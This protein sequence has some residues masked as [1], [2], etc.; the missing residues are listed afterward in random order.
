MKILVIGFAFLMMMSLVVALETSVIVQF[1]E[2]NS[3]LV[4][5][6]DVVNDEVF[7]KPI[8]KTF[9]TGVATTTFN[10]TRKEVNILVLVLDKSKKVINTFDDGPFKTGGEI[11]IDLREN[12]SV[13]KIEKVVEEVETVNESSNVTSEET[14]AEIKEE[15]EEALVFPSTSTTRG[16]IFTNDDGSINFLYVIGV[17]LVLFLLV[18]I[19]IVIRGRRRNW[20]ID[21]EE[22]E[23]EDI[24]RQVDEKGREIR[25]IKESSLRRQKLEVAKR[26]L[27]REEDELNRL[28]KVKGLS[29]KP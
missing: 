1:D 4:R 27:S 24:E 29:F 23:L 21:P 11:I 9:E 25:I 28:R 26:K 18:V 14:L 17:I 8:T 19:F 10:E 2:G 12:V 20:K 7:L 22:R 16:A 3:V 5:L 6:K 13:Q 15:V